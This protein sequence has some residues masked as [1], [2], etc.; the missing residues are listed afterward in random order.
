M[1]TVK[2]HQYLRIGLLVTLSIVFICSL[3]GVVYHIVDRQKGTEDYAEAAAL[4][5]LPTLPEN[6]P[7]PTPSERVSVPAD[8]GPETA[9]V[10]QDPYADALREMDFSALREVNPDVIGWIVIP[11]TVISYPLLHGEDNEYYLKHTWKKDR[12]AMGSIFMESRC[13]GTFRDFN[14]I[15]YGHR[16]RGGSMFGTLKYFSKA[17]YWEAHPYIYVVTENGEATYAIFAA[18]EAELESDTYRI[19]ISDEEERRT[20]LTYCMDRSVIETGVVP[21]VDD[22]ILTLSTCTGNGHA[23]RWVVQ[24]VRL[25]QAP[26]TDTAVEEDCLPP[27]ANVE[28][29]PAETQETTEKTGLVGLEES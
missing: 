6:S 5:K 14:T 24:A 2:G 9:Y 12:N 22:Y 15:V 1:E 17:S 16:M 19:N 25:P 8:E 3:A 18:Y 7:V 28:E 21:T 4:V 23:T 29:S 11:D 10:W 13:S 27:E 26:E 20:F